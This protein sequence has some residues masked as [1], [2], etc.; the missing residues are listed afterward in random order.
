MERA[1]S[2]ELR[3]WLRR[4]ALGRARAALTGMSAALLLQSST[5]VDP[6]PSIG[7]RSR[8]LLLLGVDLGVGLFLRGTPRRTRQIGR[9]L[10]G[11]ALIFLSLDLIAAAAA[12]LPLPLLGSLGDY[13]SRDLATAFLLGAILAWAMHSSVAAVLLAA[14]LA[15]SGLLGGPAAIAMVLGANLGGGVDPDP[16]HPESAGRCPACGS[17]EPPGSWWRRCPRSLGLRLQHHPLLRHG[18]NIR[19]PGHDDPRRFQ[20]CDSCHRD[21]F[22]PKPHTC[23]RLRS[24]PARP[25]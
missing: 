15:G 2:H 14:T 3:Q 18:G 7:V 23:R 11:L 5:A 8:S 1:F 4:T 10:I 20:R 22:F 12:L 13:L 19:R 16:S 6:P 17:R 9:I 24:R 25:Q 21:S